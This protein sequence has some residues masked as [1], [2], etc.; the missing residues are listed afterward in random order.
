MYIK[1]RKRDLNTMAKY[2]PM[3]YQ[4]NSHVAHGQCVYLYEVMK[5]SYEQI[6]EITHY[7]VSTVKNY[8]RR[9]ADL[10]EKAREWFE[11]KVTKRARTN[12]T[13]RI[14]W[15]CEDIENGAN[16]KELFYLIRAF[17]ENNN[18]L[19]SKVGT[20][21]KS[22]ETRMKQHLYYYN[23]HNCP[24]AKIIVDRVFDCGEVPAECFESFFRAYYIKKYKGS[25][26]KNDRFF[27]I[28]FDL[29]K[30]DSIYNSCVAL[31]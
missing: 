14:E 10:L 16:N 31:G 4:E 15:N 3:E 12:Y 19:F 18:L 5:Y 23:R 30:V 28:E 7:A 24:V 6:S 29:S 21:T 20:T 26:K 8:V 2:N 22:T 9:F 11:G 27:G 25:F 13:N 17:D 1:E